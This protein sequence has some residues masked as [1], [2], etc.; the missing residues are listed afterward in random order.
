MFPPPHASGNYGQDTISKKKLE[1]GES[2]WAV[3]KE[4][5]GWMV[6]GTTRFIKLVWNKQTV[7]DAEFYKYFTYDKRGDIKNN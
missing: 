4:L 6:D 1:S 3:S 2:Q 5:L 7:I